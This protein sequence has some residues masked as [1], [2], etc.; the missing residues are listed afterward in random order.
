MAEADDQ[1]AAQNLEL[2]ERL[3]AAEGKLA[4]MMQGGG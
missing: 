4:L 2:R 1:L 3:A